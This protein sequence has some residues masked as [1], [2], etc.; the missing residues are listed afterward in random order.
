[1]NAIRCDS[2]FRRTVENNSFQIVEYSMSRNLSHNAVQLHFGVP[3]NVLPNVFVVE[4]PDRQELCLMFT[5]HIGVYRWIL[6]QPTSDGVG[7]LV[8]HRSE[9][10]STTHLSSG[11][12]AV[13]PG[14]RH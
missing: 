2:P 14:S 11:T 3:T 4:L 6:K 10:V 5:T 9:T 13:D 12:I 7:Q 1:M 8:G